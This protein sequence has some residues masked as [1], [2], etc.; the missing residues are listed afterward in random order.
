[1]STK[2]KRKNMPRYSDREYKILAECVKRNPTNILLACKKASIE[3][4]NKCNISRSVAGLQYQW[5]NRLQ[6]SDEVMYTLESENTIHYNTKNIK[7][8]KDN[9][10]S[11][12]DLILELALDLS[13]QSKTILIKELYSSL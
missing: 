3:I 8:K 10:D 2:T 1:M 12:L 7:P 4:L 11:K 5:Y 6:K 13:L 9:S